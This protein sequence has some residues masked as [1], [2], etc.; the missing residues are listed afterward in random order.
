MAR[1]FGLVWTLPGEVREIY[2][3]FNLD[4]PRFNGDDSWSLPMPGR[5]IVDRD[6]LVVDAEVHPDYTRRPEPRQTVGKLRALV[7]Q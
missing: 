1:R 6:G 7:G 4:V 3:K 5:Y 2:K